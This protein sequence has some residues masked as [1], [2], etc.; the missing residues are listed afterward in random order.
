MLARLDPRFLDRL[1][2]PLGVADEGRDARGGRS[3]PASPRR[4]SRRARRRASSPATTTAPS[5]AGTG[6]PRSEGPI[7]DEDGTRAR[8]ATTASGASRPGSGAGS[9]S[10]RPSRCTR[11]APTPST[12]TVV[13]GP[14]DALATRSVAGARPAL[15]R[16]RAR[17]GEAAL[18]L[19]RGSR[20]R[21]RAATRGFRLE[22]DEP[23]YGVARGQ[24]AVLYEDG[25][26]V[27]RRRITGVDRKIARCSHSRSAE[28]SS[29]IALAVFLLA[30]RA[31]ARL[32]LLLALGGTLQRLSAFIKGT[33]D[34]V[35]PVIN[36]TG[37][38]RGSRERT[39]RQG[40]SRSPTAPWTPP[41]AS[42][43]PCAPSAWRS[44]VRCR[45]SPASRPAVAYGVRRPEGAPELGAR[46]RRRRRPQ[47]QRREAGARRGA[48]GTQDGE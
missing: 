44:R 3:A 8:H 37:D 29:Y 19:A 41:R 33:Q 2:F 20:R 38:D 6:S 47:P 26:V 10:R 24:A 25:V 23:A 46:S 32:R 34:E 14:R 39:A 17:R 13:V 4:A 40:R 28:T 21:S 31:R 48:R 9:A 42:T 18:P 7:V 27:G 36:K 43:R 1:W 5:S 12:N 30:R 35:L 22:L 15:R 16:R 45:R 11:C